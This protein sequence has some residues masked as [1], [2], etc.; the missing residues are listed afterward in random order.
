MRFLHSNP[1]GQSAARINKFSTVVTDNTFSYITD[2]FQFFFSLPVLFVLSLTYIFT[3]FSDSRFLSFHLF[4]CGKKLH[5]HKS[6][7]ANFINIHEKAS[8]LFTVSFSGMSGSSDTMSLL[9]TWCVVMTATA[10][11]MGLIR[12]LHIEREDCVHRIVIVV[13][14]SFG[15]CA[16]QRKY[17]HENECKHRRSVAL[18]A[19]ASLFL[20]LLIHRCKCF[21]KIAIVLHDLLISRF[22]LMP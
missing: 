17:S 6:A 12:E 2:Q 16:F 4:I 1:P 7:V 10:F 13:G 14:W 3:R 18:I 15:V 11:F 8:I 21:M 5:R 20:Y 22:I 19:F 9:Q